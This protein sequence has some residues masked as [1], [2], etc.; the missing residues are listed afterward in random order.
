MTLDS[1]TGE[2]SWA[3][4]YDDAGVYAVGVYVTDMQAMDTDTFMVTVLHVNMKT[5]SIC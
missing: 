5:S 3:T 2:Y 1:L 4:T